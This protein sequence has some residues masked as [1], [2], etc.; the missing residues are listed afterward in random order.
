MPGDTLA[1]LPEQDPSG[2]R[3]VSFF[4]E[5]LLFPVKQ[6]EIACDRSPSTCLTTLILLS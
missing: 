3:P 1:N 2:W 5:F 4:H 6:P